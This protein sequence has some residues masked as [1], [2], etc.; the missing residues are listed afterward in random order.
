MSPLIREYAALV[1]FDPVQYV[2]IDFASAPI[3]SQAQSDVITERLRAFPYNFDTPNRDWPLPFEDMCVLLPVTYDPALRK[4]DGV[5]VTTLQR[6]GDQLVFSMWSNADT[7][8]H[9]S[10][11][12]R[13]TG[14][15]N[16]D[17]RMTVTS[18]YARA[19]RQTERECQDE[20]IQYFR[21]T[22][23]R[24]MSMVL[25]GLSEG[26]AVAKPTAPKS[27]INAKRIRKGKRPF[28]EWTTVVVEPRAVV[29]DPEPKGGTHASP[30][31]HMRRGHVRRYK[32]GK[33]VTIKSMIVNKHK[34]PEEGFLFH[35][36]RVENPA[37]H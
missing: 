16:S 3:P 20:G 5:F 4:R 15:F 25:L 12:L 17:C 2:W 32:S 36:Y 10:I 26:I 37:V 18:A 28:F 29:P 27:F 13:S 9:P 30:K 7:N 19:V 24:I 21:L 8:G 33:V 23:R 31:P 22:Y 34:M 35:D 1:P 14:S 6:R 11:S